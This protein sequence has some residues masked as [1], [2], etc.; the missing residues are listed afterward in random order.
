MKFADEPEKFVESEADLDAA[1]KELQ[2]LATSPSLYASAVNLGVIPSIMSL[3]SHENTDI[4]IDTIELLNEL[5]DEDVI[6]PEELD[7]EVEEG[8]KL[9]MNSLLENQLLDLLVQNLSRLDENQ[10]EDKQGVFNTLNVIENLTSFLPSVTETIVKTTS[11]LA[12]LLARIKVKPFDSNKQY[13]SEILAILLQNSKENRLKLGKQ[14]GVDVLLQVLAS[15]KRKDP[16]TPDEVEFMENLFDALCSSLAEPEV[17]EKFREGEG[18]ELMLIMLKEHQL[19][20]IRAV[21]VINYALSGSANDKVVIENCNYFV[22]IL[23]L[24]TL[25]SAFMK[26]DLKKLQK[27]Y[28]DFSDSADDEH[29]VSIIYSLLKTLSPDTHATSRNRVL[30]KFIESDFEKCERLVCL[31]VEYNRKMR[32]LQKE[33]ELEESAD[34]TLTPAELAE[35]IYLRKLDSGLFTLQLVDLIT[36]MLLTEKNEIA[37]SLHCIFKILWKKGGVEADEVRGVIKEYVNNLGNDNE[38]QQVLEM[39]DK[40]PN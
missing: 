6:N 31:H 26:K 19:S 22:E 1:I 27:K 2:T 20:R 17:K 35:E 10:P 34:P 30:N 21:R 23:G 40:F 14:G 36:I 13:A 11:F 24:K 5:T 38:K 12:W 16:S 29:L 8:I 28:R 15:Y 3:L 9:F 37:E 33:V 39:L 32:R 7:D 18:F 25:F 4:V